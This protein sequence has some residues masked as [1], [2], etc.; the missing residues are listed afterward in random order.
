MEPTSSMKEK[1]TVIYVLLGIIVML[2]Q[3]RGQ[4]LQ[5]FSFCKFKELE[6]WFVYLLIIKF[7]FYMII[8][9]PEIP[10]VIL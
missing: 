7:L 1:T 8:F 10:A 9:I 3:V 4:T 2:Y 6:I 5:I